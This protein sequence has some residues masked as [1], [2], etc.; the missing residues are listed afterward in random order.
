MKK[1]NMLVA[2]A[3]LAQSALAPVS[4]PDYRHYRAQSEQ[5]GSSKRNEDRAKK[6]MAQRS[7]SVN[8]MRIAGR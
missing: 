8:R 4:V 1:L 6:K 3:A 5:T 2:I 7:R